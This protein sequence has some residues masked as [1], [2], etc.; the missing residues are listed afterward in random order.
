MTTEPQASAPLE[1]LWTNDNIEFEMNAVIRSAGRSNADKC[2]AACLIMVDM[3]D[4]YELHHQADAATIV[5]QA[6]RIKELEAELAEA[7]KW[8]WAADE[9]NNVTLLDPDKAGYFYAV[10]YGEK[11]ELVWLPEGY[12]ICRRIESEAGDGE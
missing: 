6:A 12:G 8:E 5:A 10:L 11:A 1:P 4:D 9:D 3:R 7:R 2:E